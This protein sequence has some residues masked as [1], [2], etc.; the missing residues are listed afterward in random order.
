MGLARTAVTTGDVALSEQWQ[1]VLGV[2]FSIWLVLR[3]VKR[4]TRLLKVE[5]R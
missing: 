5:G 2:S 1:M 3:L 4:H